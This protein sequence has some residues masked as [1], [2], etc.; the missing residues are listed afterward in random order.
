M[1][2]FEELK[3]GLETAFDSD[4]AKGVEATIQINIEDLTN[5]YVDIKD[6]ALSIEEGEHDSPG[7]SLTFD[8]EE[9]MEK[10]FS[11]DQQ[12]AM[13][14]FMQGKVKFSGDM[15]LGQKLGSVFKAPE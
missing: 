6:G 11:G 14:A 1:A 8:S 13:G 5:F 9:T 12:A 15:S 2:T 3:T 7:L 4:G 10:V